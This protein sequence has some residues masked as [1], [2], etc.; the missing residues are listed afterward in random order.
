MALVNVY[1][2]DQAEYNLDQAECGANEEFAMEMDRKR[3]IRIRQLVYIG[4]L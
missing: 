4:I 2:L 1:N 3:L